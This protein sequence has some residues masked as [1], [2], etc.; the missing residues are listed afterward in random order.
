M[1]DRMT[2]LT[3]EKLYTLIFSEYKKKGTIFGINK[4]KFFD[5]KKYPEL[6]TYRYGK[7]LE[8]PLGV[9]AGPQTQLSQN[10]IS[11]WLTGSRYI[12]LKTVQTLD[13]L[14]VSK[15]CIDMEDMGYNCEWSQELKL[16]QSFE[17]YLNAWIMIHVLREELKLKS[18]E[19]GLG[20]I[21]NM[22]VGY[23]MEGIMNENVQ[24]FLSK[25]KNAKKEKE[26][27]IKKLKKLYPKISKLEI[28][29]CLSDNI[30]LSTMHGCP[31]HEIEKIGMYLINDLKI[32]T[33]IKLNPTL[34]GPAELRDILNKKLGYEKVVIPDI[35]FEHDLKYPDALKI[36]ANLRAK[37]K[38]VGVDFSIK[39]TNTLESINHKK[40]FDKSNEMM[41]MSGRPL[42]A[43][44]LNI[45]RK[46]QKEFNSELDLTFSAGV[47]AFNVVNILSLGIKPV[48]V[49]SDLLKPGGYERTAQYVANISEAIKKQ[50]NKT[51]EGLVY[52]NKLEAFDN[53]FYSVLEDKRYHQEKFPWTT[54]KTQRELSAFD[55]IKAPCVSTC[56]TSQDVPAYMRAAATGNFK[57]GMEII[58]SSNPFPNATGF[59]CDHICEDKC[60]RMNYDDTLKIRDIKRFLA[61]KEKTPQKLKPKKKINRTV[62]IIGGGPSGLSAAYFLAMEGFSVE[63]FEAQSPVGGM[64]TH[65]LPNFRTIKTKVDQDIKRIKSIGVKIKENTP[66]DT[67]EKFLKIKDNF[68]YVYLAL[69]AAKG[70]KLG[71]T[72]EDCPEVMDFLKF[73]DDVKQ[74][75]LTKLPKK[76]VVIGGGNS[77]IDTARSAQRLLGNTGEVQLIYRRTVKEMPASREEIEELLEEKIKVLELS[78]PEQLKFIDGKLKS[79]TVSHMKLGEADSS[80]RRQPIKI[81]GETSTINVDLI[82]KAIGQETNI[83][84]LKNKL[85][86]SKNNLVTTSSVHE[87]SIPNVFVGGDLS[88]GPASIIKA[89]ADGKEAAFE[90]MKR[91]E[92]KLPVY[93]KLL[94]GLSA[95]E[96]QKRSWREFGF[97]L[98]KTALNKRGDFSLV[99]KTMTDKEAKKEASRCLSCDELCNVCVT[100]CPNR[101]NIAY[102]IKPRAYKLTDIEIKN[103]KL[104][105]G[106]EYYFSFNQKNQVMNIGDFCNECGNCASF[107][108]TSGKPYRQKPKIY[109][110][111][112]NFNAEK[113][114]AY[115]YEKTKLGHVLHAKI[116]EKE[117]HLVEKGSRYLLETECSKLTLDK[118]SLKVLKVEKIHM[119]GAVRLENVAK[120][121]AILNELKG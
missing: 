77:A 115:F 70:K 60:T 12:E 34:N 6:K 121:T 78:A 22:S 10:I 114:N 51:L 91:E 57:K 52:R 33:T 21:F 35:A 46:L 106:P 41:Y 24:T 98:P 95:K 2:P 26:L 54:I 39:L 108:P 103:K 107:C 79:L 5:P 94:K 105:F 50:K 76:V 55:C 49:C 31:P 14:E 18:K 37:A 68:D 120:M 62:A 17:E 109:F 43:L 112:E 88:R 113:D 48:T 81:E 44:A 110:S 16:H 73:L 85:S 80:G 29:D 116:E 28:P 59:A 119:D 67:E 72:G 63:V 92:V 42:H 84:F 30:T 86:M 82:I 101:A 53:Y 23:N 104:T 69:G 27:A 117:M 8:T 100:V 56:P 111:I 15:P 89:I 45:G 36:L 97:P 40:N 4:H 93:K 102:E 13:E 71:L 58:Y 9:A 96:A 65:A 38:E 75:K 32:H 20:T 7:L 1:S 83:E 11:A 47:D 64:I 61:S 118:K 19:K 87:T 74:K 90:M 3:I 99:I 66:I 25:M